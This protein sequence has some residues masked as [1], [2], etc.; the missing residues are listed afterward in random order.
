MTPLEEID[1]MRESI[2]QIE[3]KALG[4]LRSPERARHL[5]AL[6]AAR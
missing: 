3:A 1:I 2:R 5:R 6:V 4:Q